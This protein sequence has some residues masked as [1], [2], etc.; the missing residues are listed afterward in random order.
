MEIIGIESNYVAVYTWV[1][2]YIWVPA[3]VVFERVPY[4]LEELKRDA[5]VE[6]CAHNIEP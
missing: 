4:H 2:L 1:V 5:T 3:R 6:N